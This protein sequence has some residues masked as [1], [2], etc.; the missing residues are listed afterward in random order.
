MSTNAGVNWTWINNGLG[1]LDVTALESNNGILYAGTYYDGAFRSTNNGGNWS[2]IGLTDKHLMGF[3]FPSTN[4]IIAGCC[5]GIFRSTNNGIDW[6]S[7]GAG[8]SLGCENTFLLT[9]GTNVF[10]TS[11]GNVY[12]STNSGNNWIQKNQGLGSNLI[13]DLMISGNYIFAGSV[14]SSVWRRTLSEIIGIQ[15][16]STEVP[17]EFK[18]YQNYPNPINPAT[19]IKFEIAPLMSK[20]P[21]QSGRG[22]GEARGVFTTLKIYNVAGCEIQT[23]VNETLQPGT[24]EV[25]FNG[26]DIPSGI[27]FYKLSTG[28]FTETRK[29]ML[30][31]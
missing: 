4:V 6:T 24:Y 29:M 16:I 28:D 27:Y 1:S 18:L 31:K 15:N 25:T 19:K 30:I 7:V 23:L 12:M 20:I 10:V 17:K 13:T 9:Y 26:N 2:Y 22:V 8:V 5:D 3:A 11:C 21:I 14:S